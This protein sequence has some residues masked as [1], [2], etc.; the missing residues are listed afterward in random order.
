MQKKLRIAELI[1][2]W[3]ALPPKRYGGTERIAH[4]LTEELVKRGHE[5]TLFSTG[6]SKTSAK[7]E[8]IFKK[9]LGLQPDVIKTLGSSFYPLMHVANC[10]EMQDKFD[11]IHSH[12][13][14]LGLP[15]APIARTPSLHTFHISFDSANE[16][17]KTLLAR[18]K[19]L[20]FSSLS[21][22]QRIPELNFVKTVYNGIDMENFKPLEG[23][24]RDYMF[25]TGRLTDKK[26]AGEAIQA[27]K[28]LEIP[29]ILAG[30][31][32]DEGFYKEFAEKEIDGKLIR[33]VGELTENEMIGYYQNAKLL[34][35]PIKWNEPFGLMLVEAMACGTPVIA[36]SNGAIPEVIKDNI[37]G[38][39]VEQNAGQGNFTIKIEGVD[40]LCEA[41]KRIYAM[42]DGE[43]QLMANNCREHVKNN[44]TI[45]K[46]VENYEELYYQIIAKNE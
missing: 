3:I 46:M 32:T 24:K 21:N 19:Y 28:T 2:P 20:N 45:D 30:K 34:L 5:V 39:I 25:W 29:L 27:A 31:V 6:D 17:L 1:L 43:Y 16:E 7:L 23:A 38:F 26:G 22:A 11:I 37:T 40:G 35:A 36:F 42:S 44:F 41:V 14:F 33:F 18:Y 15:F 9:A 8:F 13:Q 10:F 12:A 4:F